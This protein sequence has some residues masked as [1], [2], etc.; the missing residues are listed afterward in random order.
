MYVERIPN[1]NSP[2][3]ILLRE[4]Y[5]D[6]DKIKKRTLANL[7]DWPAAKI[8]AL[9]RVLRDEATAPT[10]Q[11]ALSVLRSL[12]H[13]H[14]AAALGTLRKLGL[15]RLLS[16]GGRQPDREVALCIA[17]TVAR[18][19]DP[20]SKLAT[21]RG[22]DDE[23]AT[24]SLGQVL[25]LGAV[26]E[27]ELYTTLD[28][29]VGQQERIEQALARRHLQSGTLVLYDVTSAY[30]EGRTCSLAKLGYGR[31]GKRGKLQIVIGL[32][33]TAEGCPVAVEVFEAMSAIPRRCR[34]RS[35]SSSSASSSSAWC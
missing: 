7:S 24:C 29:L 35:P 13:G 18:L 4:S 27:Q 15:D 6:G 30:F 34:T 31:D 10:D 8:E 25:E 5:R 33:C 32:L 14:V 17:T 23:A 28:W 20:L 9:R 3:A 1:R 21:A 16:Q 26:D 19:I 12:P 2:P 11:Q 22:L